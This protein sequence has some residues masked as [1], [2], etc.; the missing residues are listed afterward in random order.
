MD[1]KSQREAEMH[2]DVE[3]GRHGDSD[4]TS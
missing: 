1:E 3:G 4:K 2:Q